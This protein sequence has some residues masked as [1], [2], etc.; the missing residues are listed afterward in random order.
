VGVP[1]QQDVG[2][3]VDLLQSRH[4]AGQLVGVD[5]V[6]LVQ[7]DPVGEG[8]LLDRLVLRADSLEPRMSAVG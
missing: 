5:Q 8:D 2:V 4:H 1:G 7:D 6:G 3:G